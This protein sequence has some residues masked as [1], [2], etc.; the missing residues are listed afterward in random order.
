[1]AMTLPDAPGVVVTDADGAIENAFP[2]TQDGAVVRAWSPDGRFVIAT[3][4]GFL[5]LLDTLDGEVRPIAIGATPSDV[6]VLP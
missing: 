1:V 2:V 6:V 5:I 4:V 3:Q